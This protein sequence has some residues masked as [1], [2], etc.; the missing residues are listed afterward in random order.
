MQAQSNEDF[1]R[2]GRL[3]PPVLRTV[4]FDPQTM[5]ITKVASI[6][7]EIAEAV[8]G[9]NHAPTEE[10]KKA[11]NY[12]KGHFVWKGLPLTIETAKGKTR[13][14]VSKE[15]KP[16][17][18]TMSAH[19]G[20]VKRTESDADGDHIDVFLS[21]T[22]LD[23]EIAFVVNQVDPETLRFDEVKC[24]LGYTSEEAAKTGYLSNYAVGWKGL[25]SIV[26]MTLPQFKWW[27]EHGDTGRA[28]KETDVSVKTGAAWPAILAGVPGLA[29]DEGQVSQQEEQA[30]LLLRGSRDQ[31]LRKV[32]EELLGLLD[33]HGLAAEGWHVGTEGQR[34]RVQPSQLSLGNPSGAVAKQAEQHLDHVSRT[35]HDPNRLGEEDRNSTRHAE[36][37]ASSV[38]LE[39]AESPDNARGSKVSAEKVSLNPLSGLQEDLAL[40]NAV[41]GAETED[42]KLRRKETDALAG[43]TVKL[44]LAFRFKGDVQGVH[45]RAT[46]HQILAEQ[47]LKGLAYN[48]ARTGDVLAD[49][50]GPNDKVQAALLAL[51]QKLQANPKVHQYQ[52]ETVDDRN[53]KQHHVALGDADLSTMFDRQGFNGTW[54]WQGSPEAARRA[55]VQKRYRLQEDPESHA[56]VG[57]VPELAYQQLTGKEPIYHDQMLHPEHFG[58]VKWPGQGP[59]IQQ[60][61]IG[62]VASLVTPRIWMKKLA[63]DHPFTI[64]V[65]L[66]GTIAE[67]EPYEPKRIPPPREGMKEWLEAFKDAGARVIIWT[68]RGDKPMLREYLKKHDIPYDYINENPDQPEGASGKVL[69]DIYWDNRAIDASDVDSGHEVM[70][71]VLDAAPKKDEPEHRE[72]PGHVLIE[73][74]TF[75]I[76][77][78]PDDILDEISERD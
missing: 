14:G 47:G 48:N 72:H 59:P 30:V 60:P 33:G 7:E 38:R 2:L 58:N 20:Y 4:T 8:A 17:S 41:E 27:L 54:K 63:G 13:S 73:R 34:Q 64:A 16:W 51:K 69:A 5:T 61:G 3:G 18:T 66:D 1:D 24:M 78:A 31:G 28:T 42:E 74:T 76:L 9:M 10:Q 56:L 55:Y 11:G 46:L 15:G 68:V 22:D 70:D 43:E 29:A 49:V 53:R 62:K 50:D 40:E 67:D 26:P 57:D 25:A 71:R 12:K 37:K 19:Y 65:D 32:A 35:S 23:S 39:R 44:A 21:S 52:V 75:R 77:L 6:E 45:L 36:S